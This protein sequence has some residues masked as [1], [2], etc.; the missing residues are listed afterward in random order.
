MDRFQELEAE[1]IV[2]SLSDNYYSWMGLIDDTDTL[3]NKSAPEAALQ[4][5]EADVDAVFLASI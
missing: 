5:K 1:G 2:G 3:I 4:L